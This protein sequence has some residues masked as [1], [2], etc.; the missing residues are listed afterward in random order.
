MQTESIGILCQWQLNQFDIFLF[1]SEKN[2]QIVPAVRAL[3]CCVRGN[4]MDFFVK[5]L[6]VTV[7]K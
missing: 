5:V 6:Q 7:F 3:L 4:I 1:S 2:A